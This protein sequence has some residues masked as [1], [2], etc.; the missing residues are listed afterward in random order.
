MVCHKGGIGLR[1]AVS[2]CKAPPAI[3][4]AF[5]LRNG[6]A[7]PFTPQEHL[8]QAGEKAAATVRD[9]T[10]AVANTAQGWLGMAKGFYSKYNEDQRRLKEEAATSDNFGGNQT[11]RL[12]SNKAPSPKDGMH[13]HAIKRSASKDQGATEATVKQSLNDAMKNSSVQDKE[14]DDSSPDARIKT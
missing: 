7:I 5:G 13:S 11:G 8:E 14:S 2:V 1:Q 12:G 4:M 6:R 10:T 9:A 3:I